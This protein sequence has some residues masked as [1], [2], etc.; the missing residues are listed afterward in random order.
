MTTQKK[1]L[2]YIKDG[3]DKT[4]RYNPKDIP[5]GAK[6]LYGVPY[7]Y[8]VPAVGA[9]EELYYWDTYF[10]NKGLELSDKWD[11]AKNNTDNIL[12]MIERFG[13][14]KN[15]NREFHSGVAQPPFASIMVRDVFEHYKDKTW[16]FGAF[17]TLKKEYNFWM[18]ERMTPIGLNQYAGKPSD[19]TIKE[20]ADAFCKRISGRPEGLTDEEIVDQ[21]MICCESGWDCT[22]RW[23]GFCGKKFVQVELNSLLFA[24]EKNMAYFSEVLNLGEENEWHKKAQNR[25]ALMDKF[26]LNA[27]GFYTDYN[28]TDA[29]HSKIMS[30]SCLFPLY[31]GLAEKE[32]AEKL[33]ENLY[34]I[35][36]PFGIAATEDNEYVGKY[37]M[38]WCYPVGWACQQ[39]IAIKAL[40]NYGYKNKAKEVAQK[41]IALTEKVFEETGQLWEKY[42]VVEGSNQVLSHG[43]TTAMPPMIGWTAATY[44]T[45]KHYLE[46]DEIN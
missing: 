32:Q 22:P 36:A 44:L 19:L 34:R 27:D 1:I 38:Q 12:F 13:C 9:F 40:D 7:P 41:Y 11:L 39:H 29:H 23:D 10:A 42:N 5:D 16:L 4:T 8:V 45:S 14:M 18:S 3:W 21:Y 30:S 15:S 25:K 17:N 6:T 46:T 20:K 31:A 43:R 37:T 35:E 26:M 2:E 24:F 33:M 28:F